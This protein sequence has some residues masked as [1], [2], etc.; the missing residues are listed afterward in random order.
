MPAMAAGWEEVRR[1]ECA[2]VTDGMHH[3]AAV[4]GMVGGD[5]STGCP[6]MHVYFLRL[7]VLALVTHI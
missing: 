6:V 5:A 3:Q 1:A 2:P 7:C 4:H